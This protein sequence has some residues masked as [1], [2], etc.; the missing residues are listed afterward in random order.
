MY[1]AAA[2]TPP[3]LFSKPCAGYMH[4][5][6]N[7]GTIKSSFQQSSIASLTVYMSV[8]DRRNQSKNANFASKCLAKTLGWGHFPLQNGL[9]Q[10]GVMN[11]N[12]Y[13][14]NVA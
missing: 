4:K 3:P 13:S 12:S 6:F 2:P 10:G 1:I 11:P 7:F 14:S 9:F 8:F 5:D